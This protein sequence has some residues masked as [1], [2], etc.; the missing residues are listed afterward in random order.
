MHNSQKKIPILQNELKALRC[1]AYFC[2]LLLVIGLSKN[3]QKVTF[4]SWCLRYIIGRYLSLQ[5]GNQL[6]PQARLPMKDS[7]CTEGR[8]LVWWRWSTFR[9]RAR[10]RHWF[11]PSSH[12][13]RIRA[14]S[15]VDTSGHSQW[16]WLISGP[17]QIRLYWS[18]STFSHRF[19]SWCFE[20][21]FNIT[22]DV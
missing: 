6:G 11:T 19:I 5:V 10:F 20:N 22:I 3:P 18:N 13:H 12:K 16:L 8:H 17:N 21:I 15:N 4:T 2:R 9:H 1:T 14:K 7:H